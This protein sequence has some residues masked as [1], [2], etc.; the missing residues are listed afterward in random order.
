MT[1][2]LET[3]LRLER[4]MLELEKNGDPM[5]DQIRDLMDPI[6]HRLSSEEIGLLNSRGKS[7][8]PRKLVPDN[9]PALTVS[10]L[11]QASNLRRMS[12]MALG[13]P[14]PPVSFMTAPT[15]NPISLGLP[16]TRAASS[17]WAA[18]MRWQISSSAALSET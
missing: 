18:T 12:F 14:L 9:A 4:T 15:K 1:P 10:E 8:V 11:A 2:D 3:Y 6:W 16:A 7:E 13:F 17:G 5:A